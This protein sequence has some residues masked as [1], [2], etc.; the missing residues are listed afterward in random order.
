MLDG[1]ALR[2]DNSLSTS[3]YIKNNSTSGHLYIEAGGGAPIDGQRNGGD[4][5]LWAGARAGGATAGGNINMN[6][7]GGDILIGPLENT[8]QIR[9]GG[10]P[11]YAGQS[12]TTFYGDVNF[13]SGKNVNFTGTTVTGLSTGADVYLVDGGS[14]TAI[15]T[16]GDLVLDG[17]SA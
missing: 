2:F 12:T 4:L 17:G 16:N 5:Y 13:A 8:D 14:A 6:S 1:N 7:N 9:I 15:Y 3:A 10:A 11:G